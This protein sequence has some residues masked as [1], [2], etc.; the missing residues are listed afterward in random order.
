MHDPAWQKRYHARGGVEDTLSQGV[1]A[2]GLRRSRYIGLLKTGFQEVCM[3]AAMNIS[4][5]VHWLDGWPRTK[6]RLTALL[7]WHRHR[8]PEFADS[9]KH[10]SA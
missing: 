7:L 10:I 4:R 8:P 2:F 5:I 6:T 9:I 3:A 1:R